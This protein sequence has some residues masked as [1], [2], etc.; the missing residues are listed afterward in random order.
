[1]NAKERE[2][3]VAKKKILFAGTPE[4]AVPLFEKLCEKF[5]VVGVLTSPDSPQGRS[6]ALVPSPVKEAAIKRKIPVLQFDSIR[7]E[8]RE[9]I[10]EL[11]PQVLVTFAFGKIF[12]PKFL[13]LFES[14]FNVHPSLLPLFRGASPIQ[15]TI[16]NGLRECTIS[17]QTLGLK[18]DEGAIWA[19]DT[20]TLT[21]TETTETLTTLVSERAASFVP[22]TLERV[23]NSEIKAEEQK[24]KVSYCSKIEREDSR[25]DF[26]KTALELHCQIRALYPWPKAYASVDG[27]EIF[28]TGVWGGF[29][30][31]EKEER[32]EPSV[33]PGTVVSYRKDRGVGVACSDK[34]IWLNSFQ[35][36]ARK[37]MDFKAFANGNAW[38]KTAVFD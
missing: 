20:F 17:L 37:E 26:N 15:S 24:G 16:L 21:G 23:F 1:M 10:K 14:T 38:I 36:P 11:K 4:I 27:K 33:K 7:T 25:L 32:L 3:S 30:D 9:A 18:M 6:K 31:L 5:D 22:E 35:L 19:T 12:G 13:S 28:I 8:A 29:E 2:E 34:I